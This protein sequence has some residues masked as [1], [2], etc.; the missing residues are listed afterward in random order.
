MR[1][2]TRRM[3]VRCVEPVLTAPLPRLKRVYGELEEAA[4]T[5]E[6]DDALSDTTDSGSEVSTAEGPKRKKNYS[7]PRSQFCRMNVFQQKRSPDS[8]PSTTTTRN[9]FSFAALA[10]ATENIGRGFVDLCCDT[11]F[12]IALTPFRNR[13]FG[14]CGGQQQDTLFLD[15]KSVSGIYSL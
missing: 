10:G 6:D 8:L 12:S 2:T 1:K 15:R 3:S 9:F 5:S 7:F 4:A 14:F 11:A 13:L